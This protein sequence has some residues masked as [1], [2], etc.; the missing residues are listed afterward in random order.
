[1]Y[2]Q[3]KIIT[4]GRIKEETTEII[5]LKCKPVSKEHTTEMGNS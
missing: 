4:N 1:M 5:K 3:S 2:F